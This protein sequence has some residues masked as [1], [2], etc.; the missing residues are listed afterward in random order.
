MYQYLLATFTNSIVNFFIY[1]VAN[2]K[3]FHQNTND[4]IQKIIYPNNNRFNVHIFVMNYTTG[5]EMY[6]RYLLAELHNYHGIFWQQSRSNKN[7]FYVYTDDTKELDDSC[8]IFISLYL[9]NH[10]IE[11]EKIFVYT[12]DDYTKLQHD[13]IQSVFERTLYNFNQYYLKNYQY[14]W[15][16]CVTVIEKRHT[17]GV[18]SEDYNHEIYLARKDKFE[19]K[20]EAINQQKKRKDATKKIVSQ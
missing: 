16:D 20:Q 6:G 10:S 7:V 5:K 4:Y 18:R 11:K 14:R 13:E 2:N 9:Y 12:D 17:V 8:V 15:N 3:Q 19:K 1:D